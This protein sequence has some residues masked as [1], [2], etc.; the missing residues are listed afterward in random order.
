MSQNQENLSGKSNPNPKGELHLLKNLKYD[1]PAGLVVFLVALPLCLGIALAS[2]GENVE[3]PLFS[4]L[5]AGII[6]GLVIPFISRSPLSV[7]GPAAGLIAIVITGMDSLGSWEAFLVAIFLGGLIQIAF[8]FFKAGA[9]AYFFPNSVIKGMLAA[10]GIILIRKQ[11]PHALGIDTEAVDLKFHLVETHEMISRALTNMEVGAFIISIISLAI[12]LTWENKI[13]KKLYWLPGALIVVIIGIVINQVF[14]G[15]GS[16]FELLGGMEGHLVN[17]PDELV[18]E[19][20][21]GFIKQFTFPD[22]SALLNPQ[23]YVVGLT[24]GLVASVETL[25]SVEAVDKLD[26]HKRQTP[27]NRE[28]IAQGAA[29]TLAGLIGALPITA[30][31]VRSSANV[32]AGGQTRTSAFLHAI[33]L[34]VS[35]ITIAGVLNM[36][37]LASLAAILLLIGYKLARPALW[38]L[39][40][41]RGMNDFVPFA[42]TVVAVLVTDLLTGIAIGT[43]VGIFYTIKANF[44]TAIKTTTEGDQIEIRFAK[45]VSFLNKAELSKVLAGIHTGKSV[46]IDGSQADFIDND[47]REILY[48]FHVR[49]DDEGIPLEFRGVGPL[50]LDDGLGH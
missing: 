6:G 8:G 44:H 29:N 18:N 49:A 41:K 50:E 21:K 31:I 2:K 45:D 26:K 25:L 47:I 10:I 40:Y 34:L 5:L 28:L 16:P 19:G 46:V 35:V 39:M 15:M 7:S 4:G 27:L 30:V 11:L 20:P 12:L 48:E 43:A 36:I 9:V 23:V 37:P 17:L 14:R 38:K 13:F 24:I 42:V 32:N 22:F 33:F 1:A 3:A